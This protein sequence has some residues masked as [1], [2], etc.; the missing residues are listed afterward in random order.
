VRWLWILP[1]A[2]T[3]LACAALARSL[4]VLT[5]EL[6]ALRASAAR[7]APLASSFHASVARARAFGETLA[8]ATHRYTPGDGQRRRR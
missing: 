4:V 2:A 1:L 8:D 7:L 3:L 6:R 5:A